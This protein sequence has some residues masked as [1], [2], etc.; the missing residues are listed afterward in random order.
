MFQIHIVS[1]FHKEISKIEFFK[2]KTNLTK[3]E[4]KFQI[5]IKWGRKLPKVVTSHF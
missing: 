1:N 5:E 2:A 3:F 4:R